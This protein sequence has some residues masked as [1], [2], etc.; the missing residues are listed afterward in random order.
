MKNDISFILNDRIISDKLNPALTVLDYLRNDLHLTGTKEGCREGDCGAC[1]VLIGTLHKN[2]VSYK[3]VN[4]CLMPVADLNGLHLVTIE[5]LNGDSLYL[6]QEQMV[7]EGGTQCGFC[8]PGFVVSITGYFLQNDKYDFEKAVEVLDGN[9]CRCTGY[10]GIKRAF[11]NVVSRL[12]YDTKEKKNRIEFLVTSGILPGYFLDISKKLEKIRR[13]TVDGKQGKSR[14]KTGRIISGGTDLYVQQWEN[15]LESKP[16]FISGDEELKQIRKKGK[17]IIIGAA[18]T[19]EEIQSSQL[20]QKFLPFLYRNLKL[21][22]S[23]P[24]RNRATIAGNIVNASPIADMTNILIALN[25]EILVESR[26]KERLIPIS[27]FYLGYKKTAMKK[28]ELIKAVSITV[29]SRYFL[30]NYEKVSRRIHLD[31][32][33]VN[34]SMGISYKHNKIIEANISAGGVAP[35]PLFLKSASNYLLGRTV[36]NNVVKQAAEIAL[37]E[38]SPITDARG[39]A[40]YKSLLLRQLIYAHFIKLF[41]D[42][43]RIEGLV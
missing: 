24:I 21:F 42:S 32:A 20:I 37:Q 34:T 11:N 10:A 35:V 2:I 29:P 43:V 30:F 18:I 38:I 26:G 7:D 6:I 25:A 36:Q 23:L 14:I 27:N 31:I 28:G 12:N 17:N 4:S 13:D 19:I 16:N 9:I 33:S 22:G 1:T 15:I 40:K 5:G 39:S 8:T 3:P 41:P